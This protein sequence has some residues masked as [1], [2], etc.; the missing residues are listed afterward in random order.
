[1]G[2][3]MSFSLGM[4]NEKKEKL[5]KSLTFLFLKAFPF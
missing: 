2:Q 4:G 5:K 1:M 3:D